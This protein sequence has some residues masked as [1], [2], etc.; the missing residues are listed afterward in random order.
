MRILILVISLLGAANARAQEQDF[1]LALKNYKETFQKSA[2]TDQHL[3]ASDSLLEKWSQLDEV[4]KVRW[5]E[6]VTLV[7]FR[8][9]QIYANRENFGLA[10]Q[11]LIEEIKIQSNFGGRIEHSTKKSDAFFEEL[12][13]LQALVTDETGSDPLA[14]Q[15]GYYFAKNEND[16]TAARLELG[17]DIAGITVPGIGNEEAIALV[18]QINQQGGKFVVSA[19]RWI[20][21]PM[22]SLPDVLKQA[23]RQVKFD[24][25]GKMVVSF[26]PTQLEGLKGSI[27]RKASI[28]SSE[29]TNHK[30]TQNK[31]LGQKDIEVTA[32]T[33]S[34]ETASSTQWSLVA[35]SI[36]VAIGLLWWMLR[37][38]K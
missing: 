19:T 29:E 35:V 38:R 11:E 7:H 32:A 34:K 8:K 17:D 28:Q 13:E 5:A 20:V 2:P 22:G 4:N 23:T 36:M 12:V 9:A 18:H 14:G 33:V 21:V 1:L 31:S 15:V 24:S 10:A 3:K 26:L 16:F 30:T 37:K 25:T 6:K 27:S